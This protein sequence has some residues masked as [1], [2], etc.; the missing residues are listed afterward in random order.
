M[1]RRNASILSSKQVFLAS[2]LV[3][4]FRRCRRAWLARLKTMEGN[5]PLGEPSLA[6][7]TTTILTKIMFESRDGS[8]NVL[9]VTRFFYA[10]VF[11]LQ[12]N[13]WIKR[14]LSVRL[15]EDLHARLFLFL[16]PRINSATR[17]LQLV[18]R[19]TW[20]HMTLSK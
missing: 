8:T 5:Q 10:Q 11:F 6:N 20:E 1:Q 13:V 14:N 15:V 16:L 18:Q 7:A 9:K 12:R 4:A 3:S 19:K 2:Y 17:A